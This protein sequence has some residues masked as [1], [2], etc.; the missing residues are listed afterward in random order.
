M[1]S[2]L[3]LAWD[4]DGCIST[5]TTIPGP[6][7]PDL[8]KRLANRNECWAIGNQALKEQTGIPGTDEI[9]ARNGIDPPDP[10]RATGESAVEI[11]A[12]PIRLN[13]HLM[14]KRVR[15]IYLAKLFPDAQ[16]IVIDDLQIEL[17][18]WTHF[19]PD[20]FLQLLRG[21]R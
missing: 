3:L 11:M 6:I 10:G 7:H 20:D 14:A 18:G 12:D 16:K 4:F 17:K 1:S 13:H 5:S 21:L 15:L 8:V 2:G 9:W 19:L